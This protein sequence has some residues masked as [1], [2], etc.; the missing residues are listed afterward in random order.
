[1]GT[2]IG[3]LGAHVLLAAAKLRRIDGDEETLAAALLGVLD[4]LFGDLAVLVDVELQP[5]DLVAGL[6]VDDFVK[7]AG[8]EGGYHLDD[9]VLGRGASENDLAFRVAKL[10]ESG[11][12]H[13]DGDVCLCAEHCG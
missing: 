11:G 8:C 3:E 12:G 2:W 6:G 4:N 7:G 9:V 1:M 10:A 5:L 13:V